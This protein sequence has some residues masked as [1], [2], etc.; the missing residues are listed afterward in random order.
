MSFTI[1]QNKKTPFQDI[2]T[3]SSKRRKI[4]TFP[5]SLTH[6]FSPYMAIFQAFFFFQPV[7]ARKLSF[8]IFQNKQNAF[9]GYKNKKYKKSKNQ[10]FSKGVNFWFWSKS[11]HFSNFF[12]QAIY[13][14]NM[15]FT[16][17]QKEK[18]PF[19]AIK[20]RSF[21]IQKVTFIERG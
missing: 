12:F 18:T 16:I 19:Q 8:R 21:K 17:F 7:Q 4:D 11:A 10:H 13:A 1:L 5:K 3:R 2:K 20:K 15:S 6:G 9:L 14:K